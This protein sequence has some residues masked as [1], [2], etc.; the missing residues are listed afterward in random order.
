MP[1]LVSSFLDGW[2]RYNHRNGKWLNTETDYLSDEA[3]DFFYVTMAT[4]TIEKNEQI[5]N[6]YN[7]CKDC[8]RRKYGYG[9]AGKRTK[10]RVRRER[11]KT[12]T[13]RW[14]CSL[15][16]NLRFAE[17]FRDYGFIELF[18]QRW[19]YR[20]SESFRVQFDL[21][22]NDDGE[23]EVVWNE[24]VRLESDEQRENG[25][26]WLREQTQ[27]LRNFQD[28]KQAT[29]DPATEYG[30]PRKEWD[31]L[32]EFC[33]ANIVAM[34]TASKKLEEELTEDQAC[35]VDNSAE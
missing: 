6:S 25:L 10:Q 23:L 12:H 29:T 2:Y 1:V 13:H 32:L 35:L 22:Q 26:I 18:P 33:D 5:Y 30:I 11:T 34:Q 3:G 31:L 4:R 15:N 27:R 8:G 20:D 17:I 9:T 7:D 14:N 16:M 19:H 21:L 28:T 24:N